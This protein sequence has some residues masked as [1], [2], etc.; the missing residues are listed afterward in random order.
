MPDGRLLFPGCTLGRSLAEALIDFGIPLI[1]DCRDGH[2]C[3][4]CH[5]RIAPLWLSRLPAPSDAERR[6]LH[7]IA[8]ASSTSRLASQIILTPDL[9]GLDLEIDAASLIAHTS[10]VA[11]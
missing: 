4:A 6:A 7:R 8:G 3:D 1:C 5:V 10:W 9:D 2:L 11:G